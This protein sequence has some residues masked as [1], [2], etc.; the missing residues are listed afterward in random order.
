MLGIEGGQT[1]EEVQPKPNEY[2][3]VRFQQILE[4]A[5]KHNR[6][7]HF[8]IDV[9]PDTP[10]WVYD[11]GVPKVVTDD[12][13]H[14]GMS[15]YP[16]YPNSVYKKHY[17]ELIKQF[18]IFLRKQPE[19]LFKQIA[20]VQVKTGCTGDEI[21]YKGDPLNSSYFMTPNEWTAFRIEA[22]NQFK[23]N[24]N[25]GD[26]HKIAL[27]F[28]AIDP[29]S[30]PIAFKW[31]FKYMVNNFGVK[32]SAFVRGHHLSDELTLKMIGRLICST[33]KESNCFRQLKWIKHGLILY[34]K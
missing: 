3:W 19:H 5:Y 11:A 8:S 23:L 9:G 18:A 20:Y 10:E 15:Y 21:H 24:F 32:G 30:V 2:N 17:F 27:L 28:N 33:Q 7:V 25:D 14:A 34:I 4:D 26:N 12:K 31:V 6:V 29:E 16:Y 13:K 1:W 22:F